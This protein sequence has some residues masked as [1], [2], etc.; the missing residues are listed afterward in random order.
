VSD[1]EVVVT[2]PGAKGLIVIDKE[3]GKLL[4]FTITYNKK[5]E[6]G[7]YND[8]E[9]IVEIFRQL[10]SR[11]HDTRVDAVN[12]EPIYQVIVQILKSNLP[13]DDKVREIYK[14]MRSQK[15]R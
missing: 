14:Y 11:S 15:L 8:S 2:K 4:L 3:T 12:P 6:P 7:T 10:A 1:I 9:K 13:F 5:I